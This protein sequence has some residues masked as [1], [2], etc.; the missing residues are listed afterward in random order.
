MTNFT[1]TVAIQ[2]SLDE[3]AV[4]YNWTELNSTSYTSNSAN[5]YKNII[6]KYNWFR[7]VYTPDADNNTGTFDKLLYR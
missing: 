3:G 4:P 5:A 2:G 6:G 7:I 1:G